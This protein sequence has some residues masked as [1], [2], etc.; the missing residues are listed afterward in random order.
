MPYTTYG[1]LKTI[2]SHQ[3]SS[4]SVQATLDTGR[5]NACNLCHLDKTLAW[6][7][8][9]LT[10]WYGTPRPDLGPDGSDERSVAA[11]LLWLLRGDAGQRAIVAQSMGWTPAQQASGAGWLAP[12][13]A[14]FLDDPYDAVRYI[15]SR[16]LR[17]LPEFRGFAYDYVAPPA[18]RA[19]MR[20]RAMQTW[21]DTRRDADR[22]GRTELLMNADGTFMADAVNRLV[23]ERNNRRVVY[24]E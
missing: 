10:A 21:R 17:S 11:A 15:A 7:A 14:L 3:I 4:P 22:R 16:S 13:L 12:Y 2:R 5:P 1:L 20:I 8:E 19:A 6:T 18:A 24:R 9:Q 23:R